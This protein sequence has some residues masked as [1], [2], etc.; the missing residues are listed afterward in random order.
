MKK[1]QQA[2][3]VFYDGACYLCSSEIDHY[4]KKQSAKPIEYVDISSPEFKASEHGLSEK[5]VN[6]KMHVRCEDGSL[7]TDVEAFFEIW[8]RIPPYDRLAKV[9]DR[10]WLKP[11]LRVGYFG[12]ARI[13]PYL[14]KKKGIHC[15][16]GA[17]EVKKK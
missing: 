10:E 1:E 13:R 17:C 14:P 9:L 7:R 3:Q 4:R 11:V 2:F 8:R 5:D 6:L 12:F 15:E 16:S